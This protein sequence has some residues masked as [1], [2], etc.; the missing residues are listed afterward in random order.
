MMPKKKYRSWWWLFVAGIILVAIGIYAI[1]KPASMFL[2]LIKYTGY[3]LVLSTFFLLVHAFTSVT[4][5]GEFKLLI[6]EALTDL[7]FALILIFN[8]FLA[9][10]AFPLVIGSWILI[11]GII[12]VFYFIFLSRVV[13]GRHYVLTVGVL[14]IIAGSIILLLPPARINDVSYG[15]S[16]FAL[17]IGGLYIFDAFKLKNNES[18]LTA[19][20]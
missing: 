11:R 1:V 9:T 17:L 8:P 12:K 19:L 14:S 7:P 6:C 18:V 10:V 3:A 15:I 13:R 4:S 5:K 16:V 20:I 2:Y